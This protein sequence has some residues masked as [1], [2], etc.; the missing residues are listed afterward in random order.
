MHPG[1]QI[2]YCGRQFWPGLGNHVPWQSVRLRDGGMPGEGG[3]CRRQ[4][5]FSRRD[6]KIN[7]HLRSK[8]PTR[9]H[10]RGS[11]TKQRLVELHTQE[12][13][14]LGVGYADHFCP[15]VA[16][17]F[18]CRRRSGQRCA[19][20]F[21][22]NLRCWPESAVYGNQSSTGRYVKGCGEFEKF[23]TALIAAAHKYRDCKRQPNPPSAFH[24]LLASYQ[25]GA[26]LFHANIPAAASK[27]PNPGSRKPANLAQ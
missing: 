11:G 9:R 22:R 21:E 5:N 10:P 19:G 27:G 17:G 25:T 23:F 2:W 8:F 6:G 14:S 24:C 13:V 18:R 1:S 20:N 4:E 12:V 26:P 3:Q 15:Q 7:S 16:R